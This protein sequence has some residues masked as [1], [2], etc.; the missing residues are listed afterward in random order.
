[1][2]YEM[3]C[4]SSWWNN[5][6]YSQCCWQWWHTLKKTQLVFQDYSPKINCFG[7]KTNHIFTQI[8]RIEVQRE[9]SRRPSVCCHR[10]GQA[11]TT[12]HRCISRPSASTRL[13]SSLAEQVHTH[14]MPNR[15]IGVSPTVRAGAKDRLVHSCCSFTLVNIPLKGDLNNDVTR[16][17]SSF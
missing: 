15:H 3:N 17:F 8:N 9:G 14:L 4:P 6:F 16:K 13:F 12:Q 2:V 11:G 7:P 5:G 10:W 1:M